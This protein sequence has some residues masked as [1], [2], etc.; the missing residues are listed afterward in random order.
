M[1]RD[2]LS[3]SATHIR[4]EFEE[5][6]LEIENAEDITIASA[7]GKKI[8]NNPSLARS[9]E[10]GT[11][12]KITNTNSNNNQIL[13]KFINCGTSNLSFMTPIFIQSFSLTFLAEWG[14]RSQIAT[15][16]LAASK[17]NYY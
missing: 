16:A 1:I 17:V 10:S 12:V 4:D 8:E 3:M 15:I 5:V 11:L 13:S 14:D 2:A 7:K 9:L 6:T